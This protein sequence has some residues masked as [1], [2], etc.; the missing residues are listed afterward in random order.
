MNPKVKTLILAGA[1]ALFIAGAALAYNML[2]EKAPAENLQTLESKPETT[3]AETLQPDASQTGTEGE[4]KIKAWDFTVWDADGNEVKLSDLF[5]RPV[6]LNF[7]ASWCG[8]CKEEMPIFDKVYGEVKDEIAFMMVDL[9]DGRQETQAS[10]QRFVES[11]G[12]SFPVYFDLEQEAAF[13]YGIY[14]IPTTLF[15]DKDGYIVAGAQ[16]SLAEET[17]WKGISLIR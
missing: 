7:W 15:I 4:T 13:T 8:P 3:A 12:Y 1:F 17:L 14:S 10:G 6:V 2:K 11:Q 16:G 5:G 9:V